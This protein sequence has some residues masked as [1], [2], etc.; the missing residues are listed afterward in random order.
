MS[1]LWVQLSFAFSVVV[2]V[3][4][5]ILGSI[6]F[7]LPETNFLKF[8]LLKELQAPGGIVDDVVTYY[9]RTGTLDGVGAALTNHALV[10]PGTADGVFIVT[11]T[12]TT[13]K[14]VAE[15]PDAKVAI[16]LPLLQNPVVISPNDGFVTIYASDSNG[17]SLSNNLTL[18]N[19]GS[20][21]RLPQIALEGALPVKADDQVIGYVVLRKLPI[22]TTTGLG[23]FPWARIGS[24][25]LLAVSVAA[26]VGIG[27]GALVS[28]GMTAPLGRLSMAAQAIGARKLSTRAKSEGSLEM[29]ELAASFN[30]MA[31]DLEQSE[32]LRRNLVADVAHE[33]RTPLAVLQ[34]N[35]R[36][37]LDDIY[38]LDKVEI[39][40]LYDQTRLLNRLVDDLHELSQAEAHQLELNQ[41]TVN[42]S[43]LIEATVEH[44][45]P[46]ADAEQIT[47]RADYPAD[48]PPVTADQTRLIQVLHNLVMNALTHT[49]AGGTISV[50]GAVTGSTAEPTL[51]LSVQDTGTGISA[52]H[53]AH[54]FERFYRADRS[55]RRHPQHPGGTGLG[56][57][58]AK[59]IVEAHDGTITVVSDG[60]AGHGARFTIT[61]P[62]R[63]ESAALLPNPLTS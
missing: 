5:L 52:E 58:I 29:R 38:D 48:L 30:Q 7:L 18:V 61:L 33:L 36:A 21:V 19:N 1:R 51:A 47:L 37:I 27:A 15:P 50:I 8:I 22:K 24:I 13:G 43:Q 23:S 45:A 31:H 28:R 20:I 32:Q 3:V 26:A 57:A 14:I 54:V 41:Q 62:L 35:L 9:R 63:S 53:L 56:L 55:R 60:I 49:P 16:R 59:A 44:F 2:S 40:K 25:V 6:G 46:L 42:V 11:I 10:F 12:D 17:K 34:G 4:M 39:G